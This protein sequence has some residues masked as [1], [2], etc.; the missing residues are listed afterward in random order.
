MRLV[1]S[2]AAMWVDVR[3]GEKAGMMAA[4]WVACSAAYLV[5]TKV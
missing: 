1:I 2:K 3:V 4:Y 5:E